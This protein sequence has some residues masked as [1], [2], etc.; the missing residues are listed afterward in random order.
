MKFGKFW[1]ENITEG[2]KNFSKKIGV[3]GYIIDIIIAIAIS[4]I[5]GEDLGESVLILFFA[6]IIVF[7]TIG[8][9]YAIF[10][11]PFDNFKKLLSKAEKNSPNILHISVGPSIYK[12]EVGNQKVCLYVISHE[13]KKILDFRA[14]KI[15][16]CQRDATTNEDYKGNEFGFANTNF[17]FAWSNEFDYTE[18]LPGAQDELEVARIFESTEYYPEFGLPHSKPPNT[19]KPSI[20]DVEI[21]FIGKLEGEISY[22]LFDYRGEILYMPNSFYSIFEF[23]ENLSDVP[24]ELQNKVF[25]LPK[26]D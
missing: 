5:V 21:R 25:T 4:I 7:A 11:Q 8:F 26:G 6:T 23:I 1:W 19:D 22:R 16:L 14:K 20:Y 10:I 24:E 17:H 13:D 12:G 18:M 2:Y 3:I 9:L 15:S